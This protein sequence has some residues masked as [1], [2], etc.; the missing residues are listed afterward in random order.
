VG[1]NLFN[2]KNAE[3]LGDHVYYYGMFNP[4][5]NLYSYCGM[6][7]C[8]LGVTLLNNDPP[9]TG[10]ANL[11]LALGVGFDD[12][13]A[14]TCAHEIGHSHGRGHVNCGGVD[15]QSVELGYPY[16]PNSIGGWSWDITAD[17][18]VAL[19]DPSHSDIMGYCPKQWI[20]DHVY[21]KLF[22]RNQNVN[23][24]DFVA[25]QETAYDIIAFDGLGGVEWI[26]NVVRARPVDGSKLVVEARD[27]NGAKRA[28]DGVFV[29]YD[30]LPGGWLVL[31]A[32]QASEVS[33]ALDGKQLSAKRPL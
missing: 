30:H 17:P 12:E 13:A 8:L 27:E 3:K 15:P 31:P 28:L 2:L 4:G 1:L 11:R 22:T 7:G 33:L 5:T 19:I 20:S 32:G 9:S 6:S 10:T 26:S 16:P 18:S 29:R 24:E 14:N 21:A 25:T 23:L